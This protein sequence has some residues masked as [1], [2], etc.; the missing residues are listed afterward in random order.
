[1]PFPEMLQVHQESSDPQVATMNAA[2]AELSSGAALLPVRLD[3]PPVSQRVTPAELCVVIP[4]FNEAKRLRSTLE[5]LARSSLNRAN[6]QLLF[7]DD[8]STDNSG[9]IALEVA[10]EVGLVRPIELS[11]DRTNCGKGAA[12]RRGVLAALDQGAVRVAFIDADLSLDPSVLDEALALM[13]LRQADVVA[14][15]RIVDRIHQPKLRRMISLAF[16]YLTVRVAPTGVTDTQC[17]CKVFTA[18][19]AR[20]C[21]EP[22]ATPGFAFDVEV[23]LRARHSSLRVV[24]FPVA[25][26]HTAGSRVNPATDALRMARD[27]LRI[28]RTIGG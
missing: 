24:E 9:E 26:Q 27:V 10:A 17:A 21:F 2:R 20:L 13:D 4:M 15:E 6:V 19:A 7:S 8:G 18:S 11:V 16:R 25:W 3:K 1:M 22:L 5:S 23:L 12:V 14:G 28:R